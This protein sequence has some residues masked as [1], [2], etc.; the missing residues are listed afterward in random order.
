MLN[1]CRVERKVP[2]LVYRSPS[3]PPPN[4]KIAGTGT[5]TVY[6]AKKLE[7][8]WKLNLNL[9]YTENIMQIRLR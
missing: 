2:V 4:I 8:E 1:Y 3:E 6:S 9:R 5:S 7:T